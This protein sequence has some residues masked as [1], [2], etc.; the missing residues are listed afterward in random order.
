[1]VP[2]GRNR[3]ASAGGGIRLADHEITGQLAELRDQRVDTTLPSEPARCRVCNSRVDA[4]ESGERP[5]HAPDAVRVWQWRGCGQYFWKGSHWERVEET[6]A[7]I[8]E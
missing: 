1:M 6:I 7:D 8:A 3:A 2:Q 5:E 4:I